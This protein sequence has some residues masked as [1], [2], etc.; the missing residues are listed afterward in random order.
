M[1]T[2]N[3]F[4]GGTC[5]TFEAKRVMA[6]S[7]EASAVY[8]EVHITR[9]DGEIETITRSDVYVMNDTGST[10]AKYLLSTKERDDKVYSREGD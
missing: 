4:S 2:V 9:P 7:Y 1:L 5:E 10:V 6:G 3:V 8:D